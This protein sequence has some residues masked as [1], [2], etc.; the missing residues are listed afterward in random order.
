MNSKPTI[1]LDFDGVIHRMDGPW[2]DGSQCT[3]SLM[4]GAKDAI[5]VLARRYNVVVC[6]A[7]CAAPGG[8]AAIKGFLSKHGINVHDISH[9]K[10]NAIAYVDDRAVPFDGDWTYTLDVLTG[11]TRNKP[12]PTCTIV[13]RG[14]MSTAI[15]VGAK[16]AIRKRASNGRYGSS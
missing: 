15:N 6:S 8:T 14:A 3:G 1:C 9:T 4:P 16:A 11:L 2:V 12:D 7:R 13:T 10:P 5:T